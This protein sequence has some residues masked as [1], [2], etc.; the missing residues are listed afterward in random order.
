[1]NRLEARLREIPLE[2]KFYEN[3]EKQTGE[4]SPHLQR[5]LDE[6]EDLIK[7]LVVDTNGGE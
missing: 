2:I 3:Y 4:K 7:R 1:M 5:L 6:R